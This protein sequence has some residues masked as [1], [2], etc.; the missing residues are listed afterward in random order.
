ML[1]TPNAPENEP[2]NVLHIYAQ[3]FHHDSAQIAGTRD[4]LIRL[5]DA[6]DVVL[7]T[8]TEGYKITCSADFFTNDGESYDATVICLPAHIT[9]SLPPP[10][11][12]YLPRAA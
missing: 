7:Q 8:E 2:A 9:P 4:A 3:G 1:N 12:D 10:Y 6:I 5:R 11:T